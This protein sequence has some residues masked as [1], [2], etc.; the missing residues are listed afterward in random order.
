MDISIIMTGM[1]IVSVAGIVVNNGI[2]LIDYTDQLMSE[3][4]QI[5]D[6]LIEAGATRL[7]PVLLTA[8]STILGLLPLGIGL[9]INFETL[10]T[11]LNPHIYWGGDNAQFWAPLAWTIVFGLTFATFLTLVIVPSMYYLNHLRIEKIQKIKNRI[12]AE[13]Q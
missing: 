2:L 8:S 6:A 9:N 5:R 1:G 10:F 13:K 11:E 4:V 3:G 7:T 12:A